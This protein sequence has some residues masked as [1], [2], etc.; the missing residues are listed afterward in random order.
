VYAQRGCEGLKSTNN[1]LFS[2]VVLVVNKKDQ[3]APKSVTFLEGQLLASQTRICR[4]ETPQNV[5]LVHVI[6]SRSLWDILDD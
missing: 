3:S 4:L 5:L 1:N 2:R 6:E